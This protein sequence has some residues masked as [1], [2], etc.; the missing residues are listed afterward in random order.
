MIF[1]RNYSRLESLFI[2]L[3]PSPGFNRIR[4]FQSRRL[5][6]LVRYS[7]ENVPFYRELFNC[8][9]FRPETVRSVDNLVDIP[10]VRKELLLQSPRES[11]ISRQYRSRRL[12]NRMTSGSTGRPFEVSCS[13]FEDRLLSLIKQKFLLRLGLR[14]SDR[15][16]R[17]K[18]LRPGQQTPVSFRLLGRIGIQ[19]TC[20]IDALESPESIAGKLSGW[21]PDIVMGLPGILAL[22]ASHLKRPPNRCRPRLV[23]IGGETSTAAMKREIED[24]FEAPVREIYASHEFNLMASQCLRTGQFHIAEENLILEIITRKGRLAGPGEEGEVIATALHSFAQPFIRYA[25]G[26]IATFGEK[27]CGC[28]Q[29][30][31]T[32][33]AVVG[34]LLDRIVLSSGK[35]K[36][37]DEVFVFLSSRHLAW[38]KRYQMV[39]EKEG[40]VVLKLEI[41]RKPDQVQL[42]DVENKIRDF[43]ENSRPFEIKIVDRIEPEMSGKF[44]ISRSEVF[45]NYFQI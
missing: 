41:S 39:Q 27:I 8:H 12:I 23:L 3:H 42:L 9:Q 31:G 37:P 35:R 34:R 5:S 43:L 21:R 29:A 45:T 25:I 30:T 16:A 24:G 14:L 19:E 4:K 11:T 7:Y 18:I 33:Q 32:I 15:I 10:I 17:V 6:Q 38:V 36:S 26:D 22:T 28:G 13:W 20:F 2:G 1:N 44:Q 40:G